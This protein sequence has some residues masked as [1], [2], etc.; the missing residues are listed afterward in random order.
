MMEL[1]SREREAI[2]LLLRTRSGAGSDADIEGFY[3]EKPM[4]FH[5]F[6]MAARG[7]MRDRRMATESY[8]RSLPDDLLEHLGLALREFKSDAEGR[9][10]DR[11][12]SD[13]LLVLTM[14]IQQ[15]TLAGNFKVTDTEMAVYMDRF[16]ALTNIEAERRAGA[17]RWVGRYTLLLPVTDNQPRRTE[18][19]TSKTE[20]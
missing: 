8:L 6:A 4:S 16:A 12:G 7:Q 17:W 15:E 9:D 14:M 5:F 19:A 11:R 3:R 20:H 13:L 2:K 18:T 1:D 10:E